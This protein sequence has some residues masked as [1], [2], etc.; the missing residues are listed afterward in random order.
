[1]TAAPQSIGFLARSEGLDYGRRLARLRWARRFP[2]CRARDLTG[3]ISA[4]SEFAASES[5]IVIRDES[6]LPAPGKDPSPLP[7]QVLLASSRSLAASPVVH[8]LREFEETPVEAGRIE[9]EPAEGSPALAFRV[10][11]FPS[12]EGETVAQ[13][14][15]RLLSP[16]T[17]RSFAPG[18]AAV[19]FEAS[20]GGD[21]ADVTRHFPRG[22]RRLLDVGCGSGEAAAALFR[23]HPGIAVTGIERDPGAAALARKVLPDVREGDAMTALA[24]IAAA[25]ERFDAFLFADLLEHLDDPIGALCLA[26]ELALPGSTLVASVPNVGHLSL[27]RDLLFGR[28]DPL[29]AGLADA[30][31]LRW[32]TRSSLSEALEE[33]GWK[34]VTIEPAPGAPAPE[35]EEFLRWAETWPDVDRPSL[36]TYQWIAVANPGSP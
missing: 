11:D 6:A 31:H 12:R 32:F 9:P 29:P 1:L 34:E 20:P 14:V 3:E 13:Y 25:R 7:G 28:F 18:F 4:G 26:R 21:R 30:G 33:A 27:V 19:V 5:W 15:G 16:P 2:H 17:P 35:A 8:T 22:I 10:S 36:T 24:Q 23:S